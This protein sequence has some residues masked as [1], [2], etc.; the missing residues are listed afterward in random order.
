MLA[1]SKGVWISQV[2]VGAGLLL[3]LGPGGGGAAGVPPGPPPRVLAQV[4][5]FKISHTKVPPQPRGGQLLH[6][7]W[8]S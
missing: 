7:G 5:G 2:G 4:V 8:Y 6:F 3:I 1:G